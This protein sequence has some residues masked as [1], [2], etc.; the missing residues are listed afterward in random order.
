MPA[1]S[2]TRP[3]DRVPAA[4]PEISPVSA[5]DGVVAMPGDDL[6]GGPGRHLAATAIGQP[7]WRRAVGLTGQYAVLVALAALVLLPLVFT[8]LQALSAVRYI[9]EGKPLHPVAVG[10]KDRTWLSGGALSVVARTLVVVAALAWVQLKVAGGRVREPRPLASP[11]RIAAVVAGTVVVALLAGQVWAA[12]VDRASTT[13]WWWVATIAAMASPARRLPGGRLAGPRPAGAARGGGTHIVRGGGL[14]RVGVEPGLRPGRPR[15]GDGPQPGH[16]RA[17]HRGPGRDLDPGGLC[18]RLPALPRQAAGVRPVHGHPA[19]AP[20]G[21]VAANVQ[22][23]RQLGW[24]NSNAAL[25]LPFAATAFGTSSSARASG[26]AAR[27]P[28]RHRLDGYG[29]MGFLWRFAVP[30]DSPGHRLVHGHLGAGRLEP[31]PVA[32]G[33]HRHSRYETPRSRSRASRAPSGQRQRGRRR[34]AHRGPP[35]VL[36]LVA[37]QRQIIRA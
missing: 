37:F 5:G 20:R 9:N 4:P 10:W 7:S 25:V 17:D 27:D 6:L 22:T 18:V 33:R 26:R 15:L 14:R 13:S 2:P 1:D 23:I 35:V 32:P 24:I 21:D 19:A 3:V 8:V 11:R 34:R 36:L 12:S 29:H 16:Q 31:V 28:G 30:A